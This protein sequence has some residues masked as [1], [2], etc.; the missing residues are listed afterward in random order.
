[1]IHKGPF[2][3][4]ARQPVT[5]FPFSTLTGTDGSGLFAGPCL[6]SPV[7]ALNTEPWHGQTRSAPFGVTVQPWCVHTALN[8]AQADSDVRAT[9]TSEPSGAFAAFACP[10][11]TSASAT[12]GVP[13]AI[14]ACAVPDLASGL[15][16]QAASATVP[17]AAP[18]T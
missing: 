2:A 16:E 9:M 10:T 14:G 11:G 13:A 4:P 18:A 1:M 5:T 12:S 15:D 6:T 7:S 8:A 17:T 3:R